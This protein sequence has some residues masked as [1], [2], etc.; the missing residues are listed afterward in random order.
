MIGDVLGEIFSLNTRLY[1]DIRDEEERIKVTFGQTRLDM[2]SLVERYYP[3]QHGHIKRDVEIYTDEPGY[4][5]VFT[6]MK[7]ISDTVYN[8]TPET[9]KQQPKLET[10]AGF[11]ATDNKP[12]P[13]NETPGNPGKPDYQMRCFLCNYTNHM[14]S[15]CRNYADNRAYDRNNQCSNCHGYHAVSYTHLTL[16]TI[17]SV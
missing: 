7:I 15:E 11:L 9:R 6:M 13:K 1:R 5:P 14:A 10:K 12:A 4:H 3:F 8:V 2:M 17:Y 16:P